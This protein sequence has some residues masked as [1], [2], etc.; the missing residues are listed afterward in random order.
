MKTST[1]IVASLLVLISALSLVGYTA[2]YIWLSECREFGYFD[3]LPDDVPIGVEI[4]RHGK[5][6]LSRLYSNEFLAL[7]FTPAAW[8]ESALSGIRIHTMRNCDV[9]I[10]E[11]PGAMVQE[12]GLEGVETDQQ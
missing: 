9:L 4:V 12:E 11:N 2:S 1:W 6:G 7:V 3:E 8:I 5:R 10:H